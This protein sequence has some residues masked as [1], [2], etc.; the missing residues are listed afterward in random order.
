MITL[1]RKLRRSLIE[2]SSFRK[3]F[4]YAIGEIS[5]V[6]I[7]I[8]IALQINNWNEHNKQQKQIN[9]Y[10]ASMINNLKDDLVTLESFKEQCLF[11]YYAQNYLLKHGGGDPVDVNKLGV[12]APEWEPNS[13]WDAE[14]PNHYDE[15]LGELGIIW[16]PRIQVDNCN[17]SALREMNSTGIFS[18]LGNDSLKSQIVDFYEKWDTWIGS[19][20]LDQDIDWIGQWT[21]SLIDIGIYPYLM[22]ESEDAL[23]F[24][25]DPKRLALLERIT[26]S[27][28]YHVNAC[29][30][31]EEMARELIEEI[32]LELD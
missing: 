16:I 29:N 1:L 6:V 7:G 28:C 24:V 20:R 23:S 32:E 18:S 13:I 2:S 10:L 19:K 30:S 15:N 5:L 12:E 22:D 21:N 17:Q 14:I 26:T 9:S 8:L 31:L 27:A 11:R 4:L 3:Y 25:N